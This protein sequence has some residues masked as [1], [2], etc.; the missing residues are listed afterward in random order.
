M[1]GNIRGVS[2]FDSIGRI[3]DQTGKSDESP[4]SENQQRTRRVLASLVERSLCICL[5]RCRR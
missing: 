3:G 5:S 1:I 4:L 2:E